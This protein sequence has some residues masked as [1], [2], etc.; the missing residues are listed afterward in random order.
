M[1][2][3]ARSVEG[4]Y[5]QDILAQPCALAC[6]LEGLEESSALD[7]LARRLN[8]GKFRQVVLTGMG[9]SFH[10][11]HPLYL[12]LVDHGFSAVMVETSEF[13]HYQQRLFDPRNLIIAVSQSGRSAETVSMLKTNR[14]RSV[15]VGITNT[16]NS[17]LAK[18]ADVVIPTR[19]GEEFSVSCKTYVTA[20]LAL[21]WLG[22]ILCEKNV[23]RAR[24]EL[25]EASPAAGAYLSRWRKHVLSLADR[26]RG[27]SQLYLVGRGAS[28]AAVS[29]GGLIV[30]ESDHFPAEGMSSAAFRHGP[31]EIVTART[32]VLGFSGSGKTRELNRRLARDVRERRGKAEMV[33]EDAPLPALRFPA[34][35]DSIRPILEILPVEII[36][37]ALAALAGREAGRFESA[38]K[39]TTTE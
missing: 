12:N 1:H 22:D 35:P 19:A 37:L 27:T 16:P 21:E 34:A 10:G 18:R 28:L 36:T 29:T 31:L 14:N 3:G 2:P 25:A 15:V 33:G 17:P 8:T 6:T 5:C 24:K 32:F 23:R 38:T 11:L 26:L 13:V 9:S 4:N 7:S 30:K 39:V 20:L